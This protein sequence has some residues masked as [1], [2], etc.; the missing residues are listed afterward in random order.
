MLVFNTT[1]VAHTFVCQSIC[2]H[3][4]EN[5]EGCFLAAGIVHQGQLKWKW[6]AAAFIYH[7]PS[8]MLRE[9]L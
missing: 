3:L 4:Q 6:E 5:G 1:N 7:C 2:G 9:A 8:N